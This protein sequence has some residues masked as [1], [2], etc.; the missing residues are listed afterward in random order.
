MLWRLEE[1]VLH[2]DHQAVSKIEI[3]IFMK[4]NAQILA[5]LLHFNLQEASFEIKWEGYFFLK[6]LA[7]VLGGLRNQ[8]IIVA[9]EPFITEQ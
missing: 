6:D 9:H 2:F 8:V 4:R 5:E 1:D 3:E 7:N